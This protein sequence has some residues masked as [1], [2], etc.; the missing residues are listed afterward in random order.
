V[1]RGFA[2]V[3]ISGSGPSLQRPVGAQWNPSG[4]VP[5]SDAPASAQRKPLS[6]TLGLKHPAPNMALARKGI[7]AADARF[8]AIRIVQKQ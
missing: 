2:A 4:Q 3:H 5:A 7:H 6:W 8:E 1:T